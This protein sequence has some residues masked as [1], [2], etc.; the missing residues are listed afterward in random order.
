MVHQHLDHGRHQHGRADT[1]PL[2]G[3]QHAQR[4]KR[5]QRHMGAAHGPEKTKY[6]DGGDM[7]QRRGVQTDRT[8]ARHPLGHREQA[9]LAQG[10]MRQHHALRESSGPAGIEHPGQIGATA[11]RIGHRFCLVQ[12]RLVAQHAVGRGPVADMDQSAQRR[13][14]LKQFGQQG[15]EGVVDQQHLGIAVVQRIGDLGGT[16]ARVDRIHS[17]ASPGHGHVVLDIAVGVER[18]DPNPVTGLHT[19]A[20]QRAGQAP[21]T[22][23]KLGEGVTAVAADGGHGARLAR[24]GAMQGLGDLHGT[25]WV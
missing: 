8:C 20:L 3:L 5:R 1:F 15:Q 21:D 22:V 4:C 7:E 12:K 11:S 19:Q 23:L 17:R 24:D 2:D 10:V 6:R 18:Q 25:S 14:A 9:V 13:R 16:P